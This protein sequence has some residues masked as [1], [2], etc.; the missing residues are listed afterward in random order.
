MS[1]GK[2]R[3]F[4][5]DFKKGSRTINRRQRLQLKRSFRSPWS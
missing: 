1:S 3:V 5:D 2:R 4:S